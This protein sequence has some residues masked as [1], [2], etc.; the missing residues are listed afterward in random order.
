MTILTESIHTVEF[1]LSEGE[2]YFSREQVTFT[3]PATKVLSG[4][5]V[6]KI[7]AT[8]KY[9]PYLAAAADGSQNA[10]GV[11]YQ[12]FAAGNAGDAK[13][14]IFVRAC[15]VITAKLTGADTAGLAALKALGVIAR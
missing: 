13:V 10:A 7:T 3:V 15:E 14:T 12:E 9:I 5:V 4:T 8:G 6:G 1:L 11:L 2:G